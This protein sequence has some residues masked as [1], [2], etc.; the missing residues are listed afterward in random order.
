MEGEVNYT[1]TTTKGT[2]TLIIIANFYDF[3]SLER[4][5]SNNVFKS[6][7]SSGPFFGLG[8]WAYYPWYGQIGKYF[9]LSN[10]NFDDTI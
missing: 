6:K 7:I 1:H 3:R 10:M 4:D 5:L 2:V 9:Y 8:P